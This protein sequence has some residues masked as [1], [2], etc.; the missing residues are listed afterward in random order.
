MNGKVDKGGV[1]FSPV[2]IIIFEENSKFITNLFKCSQKI[3]GLP[4]NG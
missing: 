2:T 4:F 3:K 1:K